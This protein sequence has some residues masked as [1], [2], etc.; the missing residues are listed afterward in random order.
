[1]KVA[2][3]QPVLLGFLSQLAISKINGPL[4][5]KS[6]L[7]PQE[8]IQEST[9]ETGQPSLLLASNRCHQAPCF[10]LFA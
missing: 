3:P 1:M 9:A 8:K 4:W 6:L 10:S 2:G 7:F 5:L